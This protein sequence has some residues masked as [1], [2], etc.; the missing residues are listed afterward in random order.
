MGAESIGLESKPENSLADGNLA[1]DRHE[2]AALVSNED[3]SKFQGSKADSQLA[4][5]ASGDAKHLD[6]SQNP[7]RGYDASGYDACEPDYVRSGD[8]SDPLMPTAKRQAFDREAREALNAPERPA[9]ENLTS[10]QRE[11]ATNIA[12]GA[13]SYADSI[14]RQS[15]EPGSIVESYK[16]ADKA[17]EELKDSI[18]KLPENQVDDVLSAANQNLK[19]RGM[20]IERVPSTGEIWMSHEKGANGQHYLGTLLRPVSCAVS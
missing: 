5:N 7:I 4:Q 13:K 12:D 17:Y 11:S 6:F 9:P 2:R 16:A 20:R 8:S 10:E 1:H 15:S 3:F 18:R 19:D 14:K